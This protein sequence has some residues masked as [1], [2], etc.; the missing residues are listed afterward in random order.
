MAEAQILFS[1]TCQYALR[2]LMYLAL[3]E[4]QGPALAR[5]IAAAE[6]IPRQFL[7][8]ILH[9]LVQKGLVRS[10]KGPGGGF[11]LARPATQLTVAEIT[12]A[13]DG[14]HETTRRCL[15]GR[16]VC[17]DTE[18]C[19]LHDAWKKVRLDYERTIGDLTLSALA[20]THRTS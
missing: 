15:L 9:Q 1:P 4:G 2:A 5:D 19:A 11:L 6:A 10:Q 20:A 7:S 3:H 13:V 17:S 16:P 14:V 18:S 12:V 8:K